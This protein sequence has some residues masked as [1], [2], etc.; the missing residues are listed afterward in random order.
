MYFFSIVVYFKNE[1]SHL[2]EWILH[3]KNWGVDHIFMIDNGSSDNYREIIIPF[4]QEG[5]ITLWE[6]PTLGQ[7]QSYLKYL[8][9]MK[10]KT[11]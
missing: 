2:L 7:Y 11:K 10:K 3:Y 9:R 8:P 6:E 1:R 4:I 5:F